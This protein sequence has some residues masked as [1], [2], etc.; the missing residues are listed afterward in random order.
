MGSNMKCKHA[1]CAAHCLDLGGC[2]VH[3]PPTNP[4]NSAPAAGD[5]AADWDMSDFQDPGGD[6]DALMASA[7]AESYLQQAP[8]PSLMTNASSSTYRAPVPTT[9]SRDAAAA[10]LQPMSR[11]PPTCSTQLSALW[12]GK[13]AVWDA[14]R[15]QKEI[16][17]AERSRAEEDM[18]RNLNILWFDQASISS[19][20]TFVSQLNLIFTLE[21]IGRLPGSALLL[22]RSD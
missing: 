10:L 13:K 21:T 17:D 9:M 7:M 12:L 2:T 11:R 22:A 19:S 14:E 16:D 1:L 4:V 5:S 3:K 18:K 15:M 20:L 8:T 6:E